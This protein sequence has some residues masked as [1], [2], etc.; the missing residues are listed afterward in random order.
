[1]RPEPNTKKLAHAFLEMARSMVQRRRELVGLLATAGAVDYQPERTAKL[2]YEIERVLWGWTGVVLTPPTVGIPTLHAFALEPEVDESGIT[3][4]RSPPGPGRG[5]AVQPNRLGD[6]GSAKSSEAQL[7][8]ASL[9]PGRQGLP[10]RFVRCDQFDYLDPSV[11]PTPVT[12]VLISLRCE[13]HPILS[14][15]YRGAFCTCGSEI[16]YEYVAVATHRYVIVRTLRVLVLT[17]ASRS[18]RPSLEISQTQRSLE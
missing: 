11:D 2:S 1:M 4:R 13:V 5:L 10:R 18:T 16:D 3:P 6:L 15:V 12:A 7:D 9:E 8:P 14:R 17:I